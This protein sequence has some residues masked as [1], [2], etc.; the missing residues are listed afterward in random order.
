MVYVK[1]VNA[2]PPPTRWYLWGTGHVQ[3][4][5][6]GPSRL[7]AG[8][9]DGSLCLFECGN[10]PERFANAPQPPSVGQSVVQPFTWPLPALTR[11][12]VQVT[13]LAASDQVVVNGFIDGG[14]RIALM[15][16]RVG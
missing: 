10:D 4:V 13:C 5:G 12:A 11:P 1:L 7:L 6:E 15:D 14:V 16:S 3:G 2:N 8:T 9:A